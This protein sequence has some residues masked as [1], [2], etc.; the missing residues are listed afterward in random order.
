[1]PA[2]VDQVQA[3]RDDVASAQRTLFTTQHRLATDS[4]SRQAN[5]VTLY[6]VLGGGRENG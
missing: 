3:D 6:K 5:L 4:L 1:M 2:Y